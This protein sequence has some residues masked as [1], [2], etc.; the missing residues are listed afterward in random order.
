MSAV[1]AMSGSSL[2][3]WIILSA[4][5]FYAAIS[6]I[7]IDLLSQKCVGPI[8]YDVIHYTILSD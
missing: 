8:G 3:K 5:R 2:L 6:N 4:G 7:N 1:I